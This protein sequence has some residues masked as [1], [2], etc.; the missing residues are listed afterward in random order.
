MLKLLLGFYSGSYDESAS[1]RHRVIQ[2]VGGRYTHVT[3]LFWDTDYNVYKVSDVRE[4]AGVTMTD[5]KN[6]D[7]AGWS[8]DTITIPTDAI[9]RMYN[10]CLDACDR[11]CGYNVVGQYAA[12][13][14][15][16]VSGGG[17]TYFCSEYVV[18]AF[19]SAGYLKDLTPAASSPTDI[20]YAV[21]ELVTSFD[22]NPNRDAYVGK[23]KSDG[24]IVSDARYYVQPFRKTVEDAFD[25]FV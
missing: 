9:V 23:L 15:F 8:L 20:F 11:K 18:A 6:F 14:P 7:R 25:K 19:H 3:M 21:R 24:V 1:F 17:S 13:T 22:G 5:H 12:S 16:P 10:F 2:M 4:G